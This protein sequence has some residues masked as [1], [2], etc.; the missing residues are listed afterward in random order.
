MIRIFSRYVSPKAVLLMF[1]ESAL[2]ALSLLAAVKL[3]FWS[4][5][6]EFSF[7]TALPDFLFQTLAVVAVFQVCFYFNDLYD[8][9]IAGRRGEQVVRLTQSLGAGCL[10][11]GFVYFLIPAFLIGRGI[12]F[13]TVALVVSSITAS[14]V[15]LDFAWRA[16]AQQRVLIV[17]AGETA[18]MLVEQYRLRSDLNMRVEGVIGCPERAGEFHGVPVLGTLSDLEAVARGRGISR[19]VLALEDRRGALP[20]REL[21]RLRVE[22]VAVEEAHSAL[23]SLT[24]RVWLETVRPSSF[25]FSEG[26]H[27]SRVTMALK[28]TLDLTLGLVGLVLSSPIMLLVVA[29]IR[30]DSRGPVL[31]RQTRVGWRG[32]LFELIKFRSMRTDA[33]SLNGAQWAQEDDPRATRVGRLIR[34]FRLDELPQ[35]LNVIRGEMGFVGPRPERPEFVRDLR[36]SIPFYDERHSVR[37]GITGWAQVRYWYGSSADDARRKLEYDLFYLKNMSLPFDCAIVFETVRIVLFGQGAR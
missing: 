27:R 23:A 9:T 25:V 19:I 10:L 8:L 15:A 7:Y 14:R 17:G 13:L 31:Y 1:M 36:E 26:F 33:E 30:L 28:R 32:R 18:A 22:G 4:N 16:T 12:F 37:P 29:A 3:R 35:F 6:L 5:P 34:K 20:V 2:I 21:V 24:G 11:L